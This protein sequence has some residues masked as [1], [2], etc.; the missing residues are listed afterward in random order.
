M[1]CFP[2]RLHKMMLLLL[3]RGGYESGEMKPLA[4]RMKQVTS[5]ANV[6]GA[7]FLFACIVRIRLAYV[8]TCCCL[9]ACFTI[10]LFVGL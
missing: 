1:F 8:F 9:S 2:A 4:S 10:C 7:F 6:R 5:A 3:T